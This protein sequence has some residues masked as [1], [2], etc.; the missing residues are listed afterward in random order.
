MV[1]HDRATALLAKVDSGILGHLQDLFRTAARRVRSRLVNRSGVDIPVRLAMSELGSLGNVLD[2]L[3][4]QEGGAF[5]R[6]SIAPSGQP[7]LLVIQGPV[8]FRLVGVL[9]GEDPDGKPPLYRWRSLTQVDLSIAGR[10]CDDLLAGIMDACPASAG[11]SAHLD[12]VSANPR[13]PIALPRSITVLE[14]ALDFGPPDDPFGLVT[15][16]L[17]AQI[18]SDLWPKGVGRRISPMEQEDGVRRVMSVPVTLV[19]ELAKL[20]MPIAAVRALQPGSVVDLGMVRQTKLKINGH[21]AL[22]AEPGEKDG[23][24]SVRVLRR[25]DTSPEA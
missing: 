1:D 6:F 18:A 10:V 25:V 17:P 8:L 12:V 21:T 20:S 2:R 22:V 9:L 15:V 19:A 14:A 23:Y 24:R 3:Q 16:V 4:Q 13:L 7:G 5:A 11:A